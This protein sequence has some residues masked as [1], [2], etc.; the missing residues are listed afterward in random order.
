MNKEK[1]KQLLSFKIYTPE[2]LEKLKVKKAPCIICSAA[3]TCYSS[4]RCKAYKIWK[5]RNY[6]G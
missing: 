6:N 5:K 3:Q 2:E 4:H 1:E